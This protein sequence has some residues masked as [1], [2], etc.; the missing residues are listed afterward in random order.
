MFLGEKRIDKATITVMDYDEAE[1]RESIVDS[2]EDCRRFLGGK[3]VAWINVAG[4]HDIE[5]LQ[6]VGDV[7]GIHPL[8]LEDILNT[9]QRPRV[10]DHGEFLFWVARMVYRGP[11]NGGILTEQVSFILGRGYLL[12]FQEVEGDVFGIIRERIRKGQGRMRAMGNDYLAYSL[13]DAIVDNYFVV[14]E[15]IGD[16]IET[17]QESVLQHP[18]PATL[19]SIHNLRREMISMRRSLW[20]MRE[21]VGAIEKSESALIG[22]ALRP[23][24]RDV[25]E[26]AFQTIETVEALREILSGA[27]DTYMSSAGNRMNEIM[28]VLTVIA[29]IFI[30]LT[31]IAGIYGMN[32]E[33]MPELKWRYGYAMVWGVMCVAGLG[34]AVYFKRK[35]WW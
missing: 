34:M 6:K 5:L 12:T 10:E 20:P 29:T 18:E 35:K 26:H 27:L 25:S 3:S 31:F 9:E 23:Y 28:K 22:A 1:V 33:Y 8:V 2:P 4:L 19:Q 17:L 30:P 11:D 7:F 16:R 21:M 24:L 13:V 14:L 32:F 15:E